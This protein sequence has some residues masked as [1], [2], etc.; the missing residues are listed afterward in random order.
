VF[1]DDSA[2]QTLKMRE[3][4]EEAGYRAVPAVDGRSAL[5]RA[6]ELRPDLVILD[7]EM[8]GM[9]GAEACRELKKDKDLSEIPVLIITAHDDPKYLVTAFE[10]GCNG[11]LTKGHG[12]AA[13]LEK[14]ARYLPAGR[15]VRQ[16]K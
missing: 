8:P 13:L 12:D 4:L 3:M 16:A 10:A 6:K 2:V 15:R 9:G 1:A 5:R 14:I 7:L 11:Y